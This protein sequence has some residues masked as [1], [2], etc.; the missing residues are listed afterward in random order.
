MTRRLDLGA[1]IE[2][3]MRDRGWTSVR[4]F[5]AAAGLREHTLKH[6]L[7]AAKRGQPRGLNAD[8]LIRVADALGVSLDHLTLVAETGVVPDSD[9][10][11]TIPVIGT[12]EAGR[13]HSPG[14]GERTVS[15]ARMSDIPEI[16][17]L[18][19]FGRHLASSDMDLVFP[20]GTL[21]I[22]VPLD[23]W[24]YELKAGFHVVVERRSKDGV[25]TLCRELREA[26][27]VW[28]LWP[29]SSRPEHQTP[30]RWR[31]VAAPG[32]AEAAPA[33][34]AASA[35]GIDLIEVVVA[36]QHAAPYLSRLEPSTRR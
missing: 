21:L 25:E 17:G 5:E 30:I 9:L 26:D 33:T 35:D 2:R 36:A 13:V 24:P 10:L 12:I 4:R 16:A 15:I 8:T 3:L 6:V 1:A 31:P 7:L 27:G 19:R 28:W 34:V 18:P 14:A 29:R 20:P 32:L 22:T 11:I 23:R